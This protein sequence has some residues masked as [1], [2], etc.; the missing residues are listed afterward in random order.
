MHE[1]VTRNADEQWILGNIEEKRLLRD[2]SIIKRR[3]ARVNMH[4]V[5]IQE[6]E[7]K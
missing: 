4:N 1:R 3:K 6:E 2:P 7:M 5:Y